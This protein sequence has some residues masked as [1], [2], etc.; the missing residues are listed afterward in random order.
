MLSAVDEDEMKELIVGAELVPK[1]LLKEGD[2]EVVVPT[3]ELVV[4]ERLA[5]VDNVCISDPKAE[6]VIEDDKLPVPDAFEVDG[7][8]LMD[9]VPRILLVVDTT[10]F[11]VVR[12]IPLI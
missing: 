5:L 2:S 3:A 12:L 4:E 9:G 1:V 8:E 6:L 10:A 7:P 11:D